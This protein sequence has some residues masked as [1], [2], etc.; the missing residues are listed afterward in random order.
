MRT[1]CSCWT[2]SGLRG[3]IEI[4]KISSRN[5]AIE[6]WSRIHAVGQKVGCTLHPCSSVSF[7]AWLKTS[8]E[9]LNI[10]SSIHS[11]NPQSECLEDSRGGRP[12]K[13]AIF[14][15][16]RYDAEKSRLRIWARNGGMLDDP[17][18]SL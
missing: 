3:M 13:V 15:S 14:L 9:A 18:V 16:I 12:R 4:S 8:A 1:N 5:I 11:G 6:H 7:I 17:C 10:S 2:V